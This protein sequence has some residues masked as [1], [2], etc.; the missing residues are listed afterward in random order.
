MSKMILGQMICPG[1]MGGFK[2][3]VRSIKKRYGS[4]Y[5]GKR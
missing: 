4:S 2:N 3:A 5:E 1:M